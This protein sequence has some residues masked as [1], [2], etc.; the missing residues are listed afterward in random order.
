VQTSKDGSE[1]YRLGIIDFLTEYNTAKKVEK[2][3]NSVIH[4]SDNQGASCQEPSIYADRFIKFLKEK[5]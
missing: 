2:T 3:F 1:I 5:L 4:W